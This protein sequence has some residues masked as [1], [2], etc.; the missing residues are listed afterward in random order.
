MPTF[1]KLDDKTLQVTNEPVAP[2][3]ET[4]TVPFLK[5]RRQQLLRDQAV[6]VKWLENVD[7]LLA[8]ADKMGIT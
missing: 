8:E 5:D 6:I 4:Y 2:T 3:V 7:T 1:E